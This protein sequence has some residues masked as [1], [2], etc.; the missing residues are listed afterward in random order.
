MLMQP[1]RFTLISGIV[2]TVITIG[3]AAAETVFRDVADARQGARIQTSYAVNPYLHANDFDLTG[4]SELR[5]MEAIATWKRAEG[6]QEG[7]AQDCR[8]AKPGLSPAGLKA[9]R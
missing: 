2:L 1:R 3:D 6:A 9:R 4:G 5:L 7:T 8:D